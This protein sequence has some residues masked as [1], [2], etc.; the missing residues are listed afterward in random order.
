MLW[1]REPWHQVDDVGIDSMPPGR[2]VSGVTLTSMGEG[3]IIGVCVL[4]GAQAWTPPR[5]VASVVAEPPDESISEGGRSGRM[6]VIG[7]SISILVFQGTLHRGNDCRGEQRWNGVAYLL[8]PVRGV[9]RK[10]ESI[11]ERL[12]SGRLPYGEKEGYFTP[13][14]DDRILKRLDDDGPRPRPPPMMSPTSRFERRPS[15][16]AYRSAG[17]ASWPVTGGCGERPKPGPSG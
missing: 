13:T 12:N 10:P 5:K 17:C 8:I 9:T 16:W 7:S 6:A 3:T 2:F 11:W 14:D 15:G 1:S 4:P